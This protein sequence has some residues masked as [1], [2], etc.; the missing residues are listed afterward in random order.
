[1][2]CIHTVSRADLPALEFLMHPHQRH[3]S[4]TSAS[5]FGQGWG[6]KEGSLN[7]FG[8]AKCFRKKVQRQQE[9]AGRRRAGNRKGDW[10]GAALYLCISVST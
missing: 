1:M 2:R 9:A 6:R 4:S 3:S 8:A 10:P 7:I 5:V